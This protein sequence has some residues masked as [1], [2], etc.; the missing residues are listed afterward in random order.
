MKIE[1]KFIFIVIGLVSS[2]IILIGS[3]FELNIFGNLS[4]EKVIL[5]SELNKEMLAIMVQ[6][7]DGSGY[8]ET[9]IVPL[10]KVLNTELSGCVDA[11]GNRI[12]AIMTYSDGKITVEVDTT[13][14]CYLYFDEKPAYSFGQY[15]I[16]ID[17]LADE[18]SGDTGLQ[19]EFVGNDTL[20][21]FSGTNGNVGINNY[22]CLG[23]S[24]KCSSGSDD[25][26]RVIGVEPDTGH[27]KMIKE[28]RYASVRFN[29]A[30]LS[31]TWPTSSAWSV[32]NSSWLSGINF[33]DMLVEKNW[34]V[35]KVS[36]S[37]SKRSSI[38]D[39][40]AG[41]TAN[42]YAGILSMTDY[43]M[44]F[45]LDLDWANNYSSYASNWIHL[46]NGNASSSE[47]TMT[48]TS[49]T[50]A[51]YVTNNGQVGS[52]HIYNTTQWVRPT[53]Y[54]NEKVM[55]K[56]GTGT[57]DDPFMVELKKQTVKVVKSNN[58]GEHLLK[59]DI[60][61]LHKE[62]IGNDTLYRFSG[63]S[64][65]NYINNYICL[66]T[67]TKCDSG[68]SNMYRIIGVDPNTSYIKVIK[69]TRYSSEKFN[70]KN[71]GITFPTSSAWSVANSSWLSGIN[72]KDMMVEEIWNVR[73]VSTSAATS[74][75]YI[76][77]L[78]AGETTNGYAGIL[79]MT[80]Y[81]MAYRTDQNW[82]SYYSNYESNWI[83]IVNSGGNSPEWTMTLTNSNSARYIT[84][85]GQVGSYNIYN[86]TH[87]IRPTFYLNDRVVWKSGIGSKDDPFIVSLKNATTDV[88]PSNNFGE[89]L[90]F[91][92]IT[93]LHQELI[94]D[95][96][97]Y[98]F[99][100]TSG[101]NYINNYVCL[102]V[103]SCTKGSDNMYRVIGVDPDTGYVK[104]IK[105]T[106]FASTRFNSVST[107]I[108]WAS[109]STWTLV[110]SD[111]LNSNSLFDKMT[112]DHLWNVRMVSGSA[113]ER[114]SIYNLEA[115]ASISAK[116][117]ILSMTDYYMAYRT[118]QN[119]GSY[120]S[121]YESNWI[122]IVNSGG[123]S[124]EWTMTLTNSTSARY[125]STDGQV[126]SYNIYN[127]S[128]S[129]RP[130]FFLSDKVIWKSGMGTSDDPFIVGLKE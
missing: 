121:N 7:E 123:N 62:K 14:Y 130:T 120:Y 37:A 27:V 100:G 29:D 73:M 108:T 110:N 66:G 34:N 75:S 3:L 22:V 53:F 52:Y 49:D 39:L 51:R 19:R 70:Q 104:M 64:G 107:G 13:A 9:T 43:Y 33:K 94:G 109:S 96:T 92:E 106:R 74:R 10:D 4:K 69:E 57:A 8:D 65:N 20:Y 44:A 42:G 77:D 101:N 67:E 90:I 91:N 86:S 88:I 127:T 21:R 98:R 81:Y 56:S 23:V 48:M 89:H 31:I 122:H 30:S 50:A 16:D 118:D 15:L 78:E 114:S 58:F 59:N 84:N 124:P 45:N 60:V 83:H 129:I 26:Y 54:L 28:T 103:D 68:S 47:W 95:D 87:S 76:Y 55:W 61:G 128:H 36:G 112:I 117:G 32:A 79:S 40:E 71:V 46:I 93:G 97:L 85:G 105:E 111:W 82:G 24:E 41:E 17:K 2:F 35:R 102:G 119:W 6:R 126:G 63:T 12:E 1:K 99:S 18:N 11:N 5:S 113:S 72:F 116:V 25:M 38:Y 80:D 115:G 125:I